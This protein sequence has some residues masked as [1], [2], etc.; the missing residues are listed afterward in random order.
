MPLLCKTGGYSGSG[1]GKFTVLEQ[2]MF[3]FAS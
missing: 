2:A 3:V 1:G